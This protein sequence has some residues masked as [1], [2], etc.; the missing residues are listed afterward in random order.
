LPA[1]QGLRRDIGDD[2][3]LLVRRMGKTETERRKLAP[4]L[5]APSWYD[6]QARG[7]KL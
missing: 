4:L 3:D 1:E 5:A 2:G 7:P 6:P